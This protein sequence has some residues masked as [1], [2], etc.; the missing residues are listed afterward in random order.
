M[1]KIFMRVEKKQMES[2][3]LNPNT[4]DYYQPNEN[5]P[6]KLPKPHKLCWIFET[7]TE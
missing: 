3:T 5:N 7:L 6:T 2:D 1:L 4:H